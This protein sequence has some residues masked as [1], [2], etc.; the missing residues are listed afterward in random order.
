M[1]QIVKGLWVPLLTPLNEGKFDKTSALT[2]LKNIEPYAD[3]FVPCLSSGEGSK[4]NKE[5]WEEVV[6][7]IVQ[8]TSKPVAA[9]I[10]KND[11]QDILRICEKAKQLGCFAVVVPTQGSSDEERQEFC[12]NV[13]E[14][15]SLPLIVYTT[16]KSAITTLDSI[17]KLATYP[18]VIGIKDSLGNQSFFNEMVKA[19][20]AGMLDLSVLQGMENQLLQSAGCDG[21][22]ISLANIEPQLCRDMLEHPT[23]E[24]NGKVMQKWDEL[25]LASDEWYVYIKKA[26]FENKVI[27]SPETL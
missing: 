23:E 17:K 20:K 22:L 14:Q 16:E 12:K 10:L 21:F 8:N 9:G 4:M 15:I 3:G 18:N 25:N 5:L 6:G 27:T 24:L 7:F 19:R 1:K 13:S 26:L 2:L 11:L